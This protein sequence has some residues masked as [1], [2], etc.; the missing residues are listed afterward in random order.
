MTALRA[1]AESL[2]VSETLTAEIYVDEALLA[3]SVTV[4]GTVEAN[5]LPPM[6]PHFSVSISG[7]RPRV[8]LTEGKGSTKLI[9]GRFT[10]I[11]YEE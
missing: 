4:S 7:G 1:L 6:K 8:Y 11:N 3:E 5:I 9:K 2:T 10:K